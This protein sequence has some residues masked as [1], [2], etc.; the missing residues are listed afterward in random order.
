MRYDTP[1]YFVRKTEKKYD[2]VSGE[3]KEGVEVRIK[4]YANVTHMGAERQQAVF[5]D[6]SF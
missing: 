2:P 5:G 1:I 6:V 4:K 3:W